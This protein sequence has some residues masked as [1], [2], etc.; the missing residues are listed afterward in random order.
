LAMDLDADFEEWTMTEFLCAVNIL[1]VIAS[2]FRDRYY[3]IYVPYGR[4]SNAVKSVKGGFEC[5]KNQPVPAKLAWF[6]MEIPNIILGTYFILRARH[7]GVYKPMGWVVVG[8]FMFHY[9]IR[10]FVYSFLLKGSKP[11]PLDTLSYGIFFTCINGSIQTYHH[12]FEAP[13]ALPVSLGDQIRVGLGIVLFFFG[14]AMNQWCDA[15]LRSLRKDENDTGYYLPEG[16]FFN[17]WSA[18]NLIGEI[19]EWLGYALVANSSVAFGFF[20]TT[21]IIVGHRAVGH[22]EWYQKKF[23]NYPA[24]RKALIPF[25]F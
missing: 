17:Y 23:D 10:T 11:M 12:L 20:V 14:F 4:F 2:I 3:K 18:P 8:L 24:Q 9:V 1:F 5:R 19:I 13:G 21:F 7:V 22:H 16:T 6:L 15:V 25:V